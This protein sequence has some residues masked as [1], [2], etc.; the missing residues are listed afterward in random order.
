MNY[1]IA[2]ASKNGSAVDLHFGLANHFLIFQIDSN[3]KIAHFLENRST[4]AACL[5]SCCS[6]GNEEKSFC[7][8][9]KQLND[10]QA[11][12]VSKIG[13][14]AAKYLEGKGMTVYEAA[15]PIEPLIQKI[16]TDKIYEEDKW[17]YP[18]NY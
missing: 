12:F 1:K 18:T 10:I 14:N 5:A 3:A 16:I 8:I 11:I 13:E 7:E 6:K 2:L 17:Q 9:S 15:Y 4:T